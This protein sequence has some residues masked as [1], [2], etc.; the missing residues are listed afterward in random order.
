MTKI[1]HGALNINICFQ[2]THKS[3]KKSII[4]MLKTDSQQRLP[5]LDDICGTLKQG[6]SELSSLFPTSLMA[7][8]VTPPSS[9]SGMNGRSPGLTGKLCLLTQ[10]VFTD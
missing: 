9:Q 3:F 10:Q 1:L 5:C 8:F 7:A 6:H 4:L 2:V